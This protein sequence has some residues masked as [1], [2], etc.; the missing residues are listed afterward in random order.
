MVVVVNGGV[1]TYLEK[2]RRCVKSL[3]DPRQQSVI[4]RLRKPHFRQLNFNAADSANA[5][6]ISRTNGWLLALGTEAW[7][8][9]GRFYHFVLVVLRRDV[10][11]ACTREFVASSGIFG[12]IHPSSTLI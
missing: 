8:Q 11:R 12:S 5:P 6:R 7:S 3:D 2:S 10:C 4:E 9:L 1:V